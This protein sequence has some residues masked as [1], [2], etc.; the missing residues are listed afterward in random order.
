MSPTLSQNGTFTIPRV[1]QPAEH[2][3]TEKDHFIS[4]NLKTYGYS[5]RIAKIREQE[6]PQLKDQVYL[7]HAG[8]TTYAASQLQRFTRDLTSNLYGNPHS[9]N[10]SSKLSSTR[11]ERVRQRILNFFKV[12]DNEYTVI[13]TQNATAAIKLA[14]EIFPWSDKSKFLYLREAH[15]S[16][17][18]LRASASASGAS[19]NSI[20]QE[21]LE[22]M[23][24][25]SKPSTSEEGHQHEPAYN[26]LAYP[27]QCN[28]SGARFPLGWTHSAYTQ[29]NT[30]EENWKVLLDASSYLTSS[31]LSLQDTTKSP[32]FVALSF[33]KL[34]GFPTGLGALMVKSELAPLLTKTYFGGGTGIVVFRTSLSGKYED[35][36]INFLDIIALDHAFDVA[37]ELY[38]DYSHITQHV[39]SLVAY[40]YL[41]MSALKHW[42][43]SPVCAIFCNGDHY[44]DPTKQGPIINFNLMRPSGDWVGYTEIERLATASSIHVRT[45]G[46]C[47]PGAM[48]RW[49]DLSSEE[50][51]E[52][53]SAGHVCWDDKDVI[54]GKPT[55]SIRIS[56]G[57]M[58]TIDDVIAWIDFLKEFFVVSTEPK[59]YQAAPNVSE[60]TLDSVC[61]YPI[62][63]CHG[64]HVPASMAWPI[65]STGFKY[66]HEWMLVNNEDGNAMSMKKITKMALI[67]ASIDEVAQCMI[68]T[69][70]NWP[71][72]RIPLVESEHNFICSRSGVFGEHLEVQHYKSQQVNEW[73]STFLEVPCHLARQH[74]IRR[75]LGAHMTDKNVTAYLVPSAAAGSSQ[76]ELS[77][78][79]ESPF[80]MISQSS[81]DDVNHRILQSEINAETKNGPVF[82][83]AFRGNIVVRGNRAYEEDQW[84]VVK[85]GTQ[86]FKILGSCKRCNML[87]V[88]PETGRKTKEPYVTLAK[89]R[90][91]EGKI[92]FGRHMY[93]CP[94]LSPL[95][96]AVRAND[97]VKAYRYMDDLDM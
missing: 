45:G 76:V 38:G 90:R 3:R 92:I 85:I 84:E 68:V 11:V 2:S 33:Y 67:R 56:L 88:N 78:Q 5:G 80:L 52:N 63:S 25:S 24:R 22:S 37:E 35:G 51:K 66:D 72:L 54:A 21:E 59:S 79:N 73:F 13:F 15:T 86:V 60:T 1:S 39:N 47:N 6:Y 4:Q 74:L 23:L 87:C 42:N 94:E 34:F 9:Q 40:M 28:F 55:G 69:A 16:L 62:K 75:S 12:S 81:V 26:L 65:T 93:H 32:D 77:L 70:P 18:G 49:L 29:L 50:V 41:Q 44:G 30:E 20:S 57:A 7:D 19:A 10:P 91:V 58:S 48:Q 82:I 46:F 95:P 64:F 96:H 17:V 89:Y 27:A 14:G 36:T 61:V 31:Q 53:L 83:D 43:G 71:D 97:P 8:A